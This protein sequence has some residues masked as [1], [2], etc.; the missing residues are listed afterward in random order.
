MA[1]NAFLRAT[2]NG[3]F[4]TPNQWRALADAWEAS[5]FTNVE[6]KEWIAA[7]IEDPAVA[8]S[9]VARGLDSSDI[10]LL[11]KYLNPNSLPPIQ[12]VVAAIA[13]VKGVEAIGRR[14]TNA[15]RVTM[16]TEFF[17]VLSSSGVTLTP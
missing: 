7:E 9:V 13:V 17:S 10:K 15:H 14:T 16:L 5:Q 6:T 8:S 3:S 11:K 4:N 12:E 2:K 1:S